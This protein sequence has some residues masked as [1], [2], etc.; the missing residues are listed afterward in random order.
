MT[1][2]ISTLNNLQKINSEK[3]EEMG[4]SD[5]VDQ[6]NIMLDRYDFIVSQGNHQLASQMLTGI[7]RLEQLI[8]SKL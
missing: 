8:Q 2:V 3:W 7:N 5:L 1:A 4:F 6:K